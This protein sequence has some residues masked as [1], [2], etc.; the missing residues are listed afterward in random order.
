MQEPLQ[1]DRE[2]VVAM[3]RA[4]GLEVAESRLDEL[5]GL[6]A[7]AEAAAGQ[8]DAAAARVPLSEALGTFEPAWPAGKA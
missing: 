2:T 3:L 7:A 1:L 6:L 5:G 4:A 8:L